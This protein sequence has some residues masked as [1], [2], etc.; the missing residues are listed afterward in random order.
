MKLSFKQCVINSVRVQYSYL[1]QIFK[2]VQNQ[3]NI[4]ES[5]HKEDILFF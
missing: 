2:I 1:E 5:N 4:S 3:A